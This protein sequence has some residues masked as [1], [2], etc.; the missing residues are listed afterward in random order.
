MMIHEMYGCFMTSNGDVHL[1][2]KLRTFMPASKSTQLHASRACLNHVSTCN[3]LLLQLHI[4]DVYLP[5]SLYMYVCMLAYVHAVVSPG[6]NEFLM[7]VAPLLWYKV[8]RVFYQRNFMAD[9][10]IIG[11]C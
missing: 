5:A 8:A 4:L 7:D 2:A 1:P 9:P 6:F 11:N 10:A 3:F